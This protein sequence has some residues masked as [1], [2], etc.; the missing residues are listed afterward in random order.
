MGKSL[1]AFLGI[2]RGSWGHV[3]RLISALE[4]DSILLVSNEWGKEKFSAQ[5]ECEWL[6]I[7]QKAPFDILLNQ[8]TEKLPKGEIAISLVSGTGKE[9]MALVAALK[10]EGRKFE[11][12]TLTRDGV[13]FY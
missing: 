6:M 3:S 1:I 13:S 10:K 2:G 11:I 7:N 8:L 9:H 5:K 4:W 12:V